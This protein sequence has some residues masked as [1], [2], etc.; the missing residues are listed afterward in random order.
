MKPDKLDKRIVLAVTF[1]F[2]ILT[3]W[4]LF[5]LVTLDRVDPSNIKS[6]LYRSALGLTMLIIFFG[7]TMFDLIYP[8]VTGRKVPL[9][10][11]VFL[12]LYALALSAGIGFLL[13]RLAVLVMKNRQ[14]G[15]GLF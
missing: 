6:Y 3:A 15:V 12:T 13:I 5:P 11:A 14:G 10:N 7:K 4:L 1:L 9:M 2:W 8:W